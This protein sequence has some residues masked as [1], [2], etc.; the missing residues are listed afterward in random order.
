MVAL[1]YSIPCKSGLC[2]KRVFPKNVATVIVATVAITV[3]S[4][5]L[6]NIGE[7]IYLQ[8]KHMN[9]SLHKLRFS[10]GYSMDV[11]TNV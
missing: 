2:A 11:K 7:K 4:N 3:D 9:I 1:K 8:N 10:K 6:C 5:I